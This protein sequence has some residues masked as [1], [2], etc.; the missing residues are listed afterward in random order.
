M[1]Q[2]PEQSPIAAGVQVFE[3]T[4]D[5]TEDQ[6][7][8]NRLLRKPGELERASLPKNGHTGHT[9]SMI[10]TERSSKQAS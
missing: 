3:L 7:E 8:L 5:N 10:E 1:D 2:K 4:M 9:E 6:D